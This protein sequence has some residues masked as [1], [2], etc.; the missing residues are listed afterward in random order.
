M[1]E[2][3]ISNAHIEI[4]ITGHVGMGKSALINSILEEIEAK[5][6]NTGCAV[7]TQVKKFSYCT[8]NGN[9]ITLID[10]PGLRR[11]SD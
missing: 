3:N 11:S 2:Q 4:L 8:D 5:E 6:D 7:T 9:H 1:W 10:S